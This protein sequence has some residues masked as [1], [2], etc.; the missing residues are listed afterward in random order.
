M[1]T[2]AEGV[3]AWDD[4]S[5]AIYGA[6]FAGTD[7]T[8]RE[9]YAFAVDLWVRTNAEGESYLTLEGDVV[10][11]N[12]EVV[13]YVGDDRVWD[14]YNLTT[15]GEASTQGMGSC[16]VFST[17]DA[18]TTLQTQELLEAMTIAFVDENGS[19]LAYADMDTENIWEDSGRCVVPITVRNSG[20]DYILQTDDDGYDEMVCYITKLT[21]N[22][23]QRITAIVYLDGTQ[24]TNEQA[25][26]ASDIVGQLNLQFGT[27]ASLEAVVNEALASKSVSA[28]VTVDQSELNYT[29][30]AQT[31][32]VTAVVSADEEP[33]S[34]TGYFLR[35]VSSAQGE[36]EETL[37]FTKTGTDA[38]GNGIW[39]AST[40]LTLPGTYVFTALTL[41]G[42]EY[43]ISQLSGDDTD[44]VT[45]TMSGYSVS[46]VSGDDYVSGANI[47]DTG[48]S[49]TADVSVTLYSTVLDALDDVE[50]VQGVFLSEDGTRA[51]ADMSLVS[52]DRS[53]ATWTGTFRFSSSGTYTL[54]YVYIDG[55]AYGLPDDIAY[56]LNVTLGLTA[57]IWI[58]TEA[59][60]EEGETATYFMLPESGVVTL[61]VNVA[62]TDDAGNAL[63]AED[64]GSDTL[65]IKYESDTIFDLDAD[66]TY[67]SGIGRYTGQFQVYGG[68]VYTLTSLTAA[69][70]AVTNI[71]NAPTITAL[72]YSQAVTEYYADSSAESQVILTSKAYLS[73]DL[74]NATEL[75][76]TATV[77]DEDTGETY[78]GITGTLTNSDISPDGQSVSTYVF[79]LPTDEDGATQ[80]GYWSLT[81]LTLTDFIDAD[82]TEYS[83]ADG[84]Y[85]TWNMADVTTE[86]VSTKVVSTI[87]VDLAYGGTETSFT[88]EFMTDHI[89]EG[90]T[91]TL[92]DYEGDPIPE[93][94]VT[95]TKLV[96]GR[97]TQNTT[98]TS[99]STYPAEFDMELPWVYN[100][101]SGTTLNFYSGSQEIVRPAM[102]ASGEYSDDGIWSFTLNFRVSSGT[103]GKYD[104]Y[105][106]SAMF[107]V[108]ERTFG[109]TYSGLSTTY[110]NGL[111]WEMTDDIDS[112]TTSV[113]VQDQN[114]GPVVVQSN[115]LERVTVAWDDMT[116]AVD[117]LSPDA[118]TL[119]RIGYSTDEE[120][121]NL[122]LTHNYMSS[123]STKTTAYVMDEVGK[124]SDDNLTYTPS[125]VTLTLTG[126]GDFDK[127]VLSTATDA[128]DITEVVFTD[129]STSKTTTDVQCTN[130]SGSATFMSTNTIA[131]YCDQLVCTI[132]LSTT[133]AVTYY[134]PVTS[135][136]T[137]IVVNGYYKVNTTYMASDYQDE[138]D[139]FY[140]ALAAALPTERITKASATGV[141]LS[142]LTIGSGTSSSSPKT[143]Y[144][145]YTFPENVTFE[146]DGV[147]Y[148]VTQWKYRQASGAAHTALST[149]TTTVT[150]GTS[151]SITRSFI[152]YPYNFEVVE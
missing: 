145:T 125:R 73:V 142:T 22:E 134:A 152:I 148:K 4:Y 106:P 55:E 10:T 50:T 144:I 44:R 68:G 94:Y 69:G 115:T 97:N 118:N 131:M 2:S 33:T 38:N 98:S 139:D 79:E 129:N 24:L 5:D 81:S 52:S 63:T 1:S 65:V 34:V 35:Q 114:A 46:S 53:S 147:T 128:K 126:G 92:T 141:E 28:T 37:T 108:D 104:R 40:T 103:S 138:S 66:L 143:G 57:R 116:V 11:E 83:S 18:L 82:G 21:Q 132:K 150:A 133:I 111:F 78:D 43:T 149:S 96:Y 59:E 117:S 122:L 12:G 19:V 49:T 25:S 13:G 89:V 8:A 45:V 27:T 102:V 62:L 130:T 99:I 56:T 48:N 61:D 127:A 124:D 6:M 88:G 85:C 86:E 54:A 30:E 32:T 95:D 136:A 101:S 64:V 31:V 29:G 74:T 67:D 119:F 87:Y 36:R 26:A 58:S 3:T 23:A 16:F 112:S 113:E 84:E 14:D 9:T 60:L 107:T 80:D 42:K 7:A 91:M 51:S 110:S 39:T 120:L 93:S 76:V 123:T 41:D 109:V 71:S 140:D 105:E 137:N 20:S 77:E 75:S 121:D 70:T 100:F 17:D 72:A 15:N 146:V 151:K 90:S 135:Y 47:F